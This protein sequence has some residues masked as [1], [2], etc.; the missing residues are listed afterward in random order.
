MIYR[1]QKK[2]IKISIISFLLVFTVVV[3]TILL[4]IYSQSVSDSDKIAD[5]IMENDG[6]FPSFNEKLEVPDN[7][8]FPP[9][10]IGPET[11]FTTRFFIVHFDQNGRYLSTDLS[12]I[13]SISDDEAEKYGYQAL[14]KN[15]ERGCIHL[16]RFK[17]V[18]SENGTS[19]V[20][21]NNDPLKMTVKR[22]IAAA[23]FFLLLGGVIFTTIVIILSKRAVRPVAESYEKQKQFITN[24]NHEL[25]TPLTLMLTNLDI[26]ES[27][28]G[29]NEW[30]DDIR[31]EG[32]KLAELIN[33]MLYLSRM[34][35]ENT[36]IRRSTFDLSEMIN[37]T[38]DIFQPVISEKDLVFTTD[39][40]ANI[41]YLGEDILICQMISLLLENAIKYCDANGSIAMTLKDDQHPIFSIENHYSAVGKLELDSLFDRFYRADNARTSGA[42]FGLGLSVAK[43]IVEKHNGK[44]WVEN[45]NNSKIR[46]SVKL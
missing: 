22:I 26:I 31:F 15:K 36:Y 17:A 33:Q 32:Q 43:S 5:I 35:E 4:F 18:S 11:P 20:F 27:E 30:L 23:F 24:A 25:K 41:S 10:G 16:Y 2:F 29:K 8:E 6:D 45:V 3:S 13:A 9:N 40:E 21:I 44:I 39:I 7:L 19:I 12:S 28:T 37:E 38:A 46:F 1:L 34:D 42:G 14:Q